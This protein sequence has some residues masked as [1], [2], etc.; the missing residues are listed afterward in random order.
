M[1][2]ANHFWFRMFMLCL[3]YFPAI[4]QII[5]WKSHTCITWFYCNQSYQNTIIQIS[6][7]YYAIKTLT[8]SVEREVEWKRGRAVMASRKFWIFG[9]LAVLFLASKYKCIIISLENYK[10]DLPI[11]F[12]VPMVQNGALCCW[13]VRCYLSRKIIFL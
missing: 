7:N 8:I 6:R 9:L 13:F 5:Q 11:K 12:T 4:F 3:D 10:K 2:S 1:L